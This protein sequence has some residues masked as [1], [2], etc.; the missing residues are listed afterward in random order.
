MD[1]VS[2]S[3]SLALVS[4]IASGLTEIGKDAIADTYNALKTKLLEKFGENSNIP[5]AISSLEESPNSE[6]VKANLVKE[7]NKVEADKD[8]ELLEMA[9][10]LIELLSREK[11]VSTKTQTVKGNYNAGSLGGGVASVNINAPSKLNHKKTK[12]DNK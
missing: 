3:I 7:I 1:P 4:G 6:I 12:P 11:N 5:K 2:L 9:S 8:S 10:F